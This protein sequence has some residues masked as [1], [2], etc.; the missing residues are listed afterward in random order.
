ML[1]LGLP[2]GHNEH[3]RHFETWPPSNPTWQVTVH[4]LGWKWHWRTGRI[5][6]LYLL[7]SSHNFSSWL[8]FHVT[9]SQVIAQV[10]GEVVVA[11]NIYWVF[12]ICQ[13]L[14][15]GSPY[16]IQC[17]GSSSDLQVNGGIR[18]KLIKLLKIILQSCQELQTLIYL[19]TALSS[20][21]LIINSPS[22]CLHDS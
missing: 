4:G 2:G 15:W 1:S 21:P 18:K 12:I 16:P 6:Q 19:A 9:E 8:N 3:L 13:V 20:W 10:S 14:C 22:N 5:S 11:K 17:M 7:Q